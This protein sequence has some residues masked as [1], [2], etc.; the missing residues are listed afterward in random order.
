[1]TVAY[2]DSSWRDAIAFLVMI[3]IL[4]LRPRGLFG[5]PAFE[6]A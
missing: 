2:L 4:L 3:L 1:M 5:K 6:R